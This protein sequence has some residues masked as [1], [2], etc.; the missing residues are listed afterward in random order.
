[1]MITGNSI[2]V[3]R[4]CTLRSALKLELRGLKM[5]RGRTAYSIIKSEF[6]LKG[7]KESVY[8]QM[9]ELCEKMKGE[10]VAG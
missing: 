1:M 8:T 10:I 2:D 4:M 5:S 9:C 3:Y 6:G 7:S